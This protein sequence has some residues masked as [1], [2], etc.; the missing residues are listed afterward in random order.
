M[1]P[2]AALLP[3]LAACG[4][5]VSDPVVPE[6]VLAGLPANV[7]AGQAFADDENC[8]FYIDGSGGPQPVLN[9]AR[10]PVCVI[11]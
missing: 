11:P 4:V 8:W 5:A 9:A 2:A 1:K 3:L 6:V 10:E 7:P